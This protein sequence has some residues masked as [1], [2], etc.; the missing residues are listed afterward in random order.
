[1]NKKTYINDVPELVNQWHTKKN[2]KLNL[3]DCSV[4]SRKKVWWKCSKYSDHEWPSP[5]QDRYKQI[6]KSGRESCPFCS[7]KRVSQSNCLAT[8]FPE[9]KEQ[10]HPTKNKPLTPEMV[11]AGSSKIVWWHC[12]IHAREWQ[13]AISNRKKQNFNIGCCQNQSKIKLKQPSIVFDDR[14]MKLWHTTKNRKLD[15]NNLTRG[16]AQKVWW[17]CSI[18]KDHSWPASVFNVA[19]GRGCPM[20]SGK[21]VVKS[22]CLK[23]TNPEIAKEWHPNKNKQYKP[24]EF[25]AGSGKIIW[26]KCSNKHEWPAPIHKRQ[27][28]G[29]PYCKGQKVN[30]TNSL[31]ALFPEISK[32]WHKTKN[33]DLKPTDFSASSGKLIWW[34]C[35]LN[36]N[37]IWRA[38]I[39]DRTRG[40]DCNQCADHGYRIDKEAIFYLHKIVLKDG[41]NAFKYGITNQLDGN[42]EKQLKQNLAGIM[43]TWELIYC[44]GVTALK[45]ENSCKINFGSTGFLNKTQL[46][47][48]FTETTSFNETNYNFI[49]KAIKK[50]VKN[51]ENDFVRKSLVKYNINNH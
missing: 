48:G 15:A 38:S 30:N 10:W 32:Q 6:I 9:A 45:I 22:N 17:Q 37:H 47:V 7:G 13:A 14:L 24:T 11:T 33:V 29:C 44:D 49:I 18:A 46:K 35:S 50:G 23:T 3:T 36:K 28:R 4:F 39:A 16:S 8:K 2:L 19:N 21:M 51:T 5:I 43:E 41:S 34:R 42:R 31:K 20:C 27:T 1:M 25:T 26:W 40:R 12:K